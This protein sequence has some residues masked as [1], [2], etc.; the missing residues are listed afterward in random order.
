M[1]ARVV[2]IISSNVV[3]NIISMLKYSSLI[4]SNGEKTLMVILFSYLLAIVLFGILL[5]VF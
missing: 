1:L 2:L 4:I 5:R 3:L